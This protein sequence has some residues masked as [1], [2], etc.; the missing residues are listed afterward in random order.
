MDYVDCLGRTRTCLRRDLSLIKEKDSDLKLIVEARRKE[1]GEDIQCNEQSNKET[2]KQDTEIGESNELLSSDMRRELL[3]Q[4]WEKEEEEI[5]NKTD[6]HYQ[7]VLFDGLLKCIAT[8]YVLLTF[9]IY[10]GK[11]SRCWIL[12][13]L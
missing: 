6:V 10:R 9:I 11:K 1:S 7:D 5:R 13:L 12:Q 3:R 8:S 4:K 2:V